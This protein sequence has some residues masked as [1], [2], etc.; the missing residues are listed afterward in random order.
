M[1]DFLSSPVLFPSDMDSSK[2]SAGP[3][4]KLPEP[5]NWSDYDYY[6]TT[7]D[8]SMINLTD[9]IRLEPIEENDLMHVYAPFLP[10]NHTST[11]VL[12]KAKLGSQSQRLT[13]L[14]LAQSMVNA[15][16]LPS[17]ELNHEQ[18]LLRANLRGALDAVE[19]D[20]QQNA[21]DCLFPSH[22]RSLHSCDDDN[23]DQWSWR[24][25]LMD[26][27]D[28]VYSNC[29]SPSSHSLVNDQCHSTPILLESGLSSHMIID[30]DVDNDEDDE[31]GAQQSLTTA[32][33]EQP[34]CL[35]PVKNKKKTKS[36][37]KWMIK[38]KKAATK[39]MVDTGSK[40]R[41]WVKN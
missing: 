21:T 6:N 11:T 9:L 32:I 1:V 14:A 10:L 27:P 39:S 5:A 24:E 26:V 7:T 33:M 4:F 40:V 38:I 8:K 30:D 37:K 25:E 2:L 3:T 36:L 22:H 18:Q 29:S 23:S 34:T 41:R 16:K 31:S 13:L 35:S 17:I 28:L 19:N 15:Y 20:M 12:Q